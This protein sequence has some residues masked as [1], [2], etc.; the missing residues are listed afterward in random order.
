[1]TKNIVILPMPYSK[2]WW[3]TPSCPTLMKH[4]IY[5]KHSCLQKGGGI[6]VQTT[7]SHRPTNSQTV[8]HM[9]PNSLKLD[10]KCI[11]STTLKKTNKCKINAREKFT[12]LPKQSK[13]ILACEKGLSKDCIG[14]HW[15]CKALSYRE[16]KLILSNAAVC[17]VFLFLFLG[18]AIHGNRKLP[19]AQGKTYKGV[20]Q[21]PCQYKFF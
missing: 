13:H 19:T 21:M 3:G 9:I 1:M 7:V 12:T 8:G 14:M 11:W 15:H 2:T 10:V 4:S 20:D 5:K 16:C 6:I 17:L 18:C